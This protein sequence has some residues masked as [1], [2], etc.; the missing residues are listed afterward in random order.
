MLTLKNICCV[1]VFDSN[2]KYAFVNYVFKINSKDTSA[3]TM[4]VGWLYCLLWTGICPVTHIFFVNF[5]SQVHVLSHS[6]S[7]KWSSK[8]KKIIWWDEKKFLRGRKYIMVTNIWNKVF[9][10]GPS[11]ICGEQ[12]L[13]S[14]KGYGL[15][16]KPY[17]FNFIEG[18]LPQ[19][20]LDHSWIL[21]PIY[22][23]T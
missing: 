19:I 13:K 23:L 14:L 12:S 17:P 4:E 2:F 7:W 3:T 5:Y 11:K 16:S 10:N 21:C 20:L 9:K 15:L 8:N 6:A 18:F 1:S 22:C